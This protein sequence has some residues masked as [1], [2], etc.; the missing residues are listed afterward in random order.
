V[1]ASY[2][3]SIA[4]GQGAI[5]GAN[6]TTG[7]STGA[8]GSTLGGYQGAQGSY[9]GAS[10]IQNQGY[11]NQM[12]AY[13]ANQSQISGYLGA[14][15]GVAGMMMADG[16][17]PGRR[18]ALTLDHATGKPVYDSQPGT[19]DY[20]A[21]DGSGIDD[22][23]DIKASTGEYIIPADVVKA[24]GEEFFDKLVERYHTPAAEQESAGAA[25]HR[26]MPSLTAP[27][28]HGR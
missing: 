16:G 19:I 9:N 12:A 27:M 2:G 18:R 28:A 5:G 4:A 17:T 23:V 6:Q 3:Q 22:Q 24:K 13:N 25:A 7:T 8:F 11:Q 1:A 21:G 20:G 26:V 15:G 14:A 10:N